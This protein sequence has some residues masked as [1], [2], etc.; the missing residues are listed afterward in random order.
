MDVPEDVFVE[1]DLACDVDVLLPEADGF[2]CTCTRV[3]LPEGRVLVGDVARFGV[4]EVPSDGNERF[5]TSDV[6]AGTS[7]DVDGS[8]SDGTLAPPVGSETGAVNELIGM[9]PRPLGTSEDTSGNWAAGTANSGIA[10]ADK[11]ISGNAAG[12]VTPVG[13]TEVPV[14]ALVPLEGTTDVALDVAP[15]TAALTAA[16]AGGNVTV[17]ASRLTSPPSD[18]ARPSNLVPAPNVMSL[19]ARMVPASDVDG[20]SA[21]LP[22]TN[23]RT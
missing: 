20:A 1:P 21:A 10:M 11:G 8:E 19:F 15:C 23:H 18:R 3:P 16:T 9:T 13:G 5:G 6:T 17:L 12:T 2:V 4:R 7:D 14:E 22:P